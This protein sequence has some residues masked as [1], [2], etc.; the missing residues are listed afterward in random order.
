MSYAELHCLTNFTF[1]RG[2]SQPEEL[3]RRARQLKYAALAITDECSVAGVV[4]AHVAA[5]APESSAPPL[6]LIVGAEFRLTCGTRLVALAMNRRGYARLCRLITCGRRAAPKGE[7]ALTR[8][9]VECLEQCLILWLP[10]LEPD[11][12]AGAW[13]RE[14]F[15]A[16]VWIAVELTRDGA[17]RE[18]LETLRQLGH[19]LELPLLA[20]G[21]VHMHV[22]ERRNLQD[23]LTAIRHNVPLAEA[24][25]HLYPNGERHLREPKRLARLYPRE[26]LSQTLVVAERCTFSLDELRYEYP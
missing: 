13:L 1:L 17:D 19:R 24:G 25:W 6:K 8:A 22:R 11:A 26:L 12:A 2:A 15:P 10:A 23:A 5:K 21:D 7:Y 9:D 20:S 14:R 16:S 18:R 4:R 3:V